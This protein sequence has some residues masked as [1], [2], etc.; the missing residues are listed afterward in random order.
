MARELYNWN[1]LVA[2]S[3]IALE[4]LKLKNVEITSER[5]IAELNPLQTLYGKEGVI[6][7]ANRYLNNK[8]NKDI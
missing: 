1:Q 6:G 8:N 4:N 3:V 7:L 5:F 2:Y